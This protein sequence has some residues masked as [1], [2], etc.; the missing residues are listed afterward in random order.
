MDI[1][2]QADKFRDVFQNSLKINS[3]SLS[4]RTLLSERNQKRI[5]YSPYYQRNY[6]WD[7]EKQSFFIESIILGTE[8]PPLILFK[9]G[10]KIEVI[11]G[12]QRFETL[13][14]FMESDLTLS[15]KGLKE[16]RNLGKKN[17]NT[18]SEELKSTFLESNIRVFEF[19]VINHPNL[20]EEIVD[21]VKKEIFRRYNTGITP[22]TRSELDSAKYDTDIFSGHFERVLKEDNDFLKDFNDCFF[23]SDKIYNEAANDGIVS[24]NVDQIR[25]FRILSEFPISTYAGTSNRT[26]II[27]LLYDFSNTNSIDLEKDFEDLKRTIEN[28]LRIY[29]LL[30]PKKLTLNK[31]IFECFIW[32]HSILN[33]E[34]IDFD[35]SIGNYIE[36]I[37][38][39][40]HYFTMDNYHYYRNIIERYKITADFFKKHTNF[41]F[42]IYIR[43]SEFSRKISDLRQTEE[44][45]SK[46]IDELSHLRSHKQNPTSIPVDEIRHDLKTSNYLVRPS[47]QRQE[48]INVRKASSIIESIL[49]GI[50]LPPIFVFK[51]VNGVK[52]VVDGQQRLLSIIGFLGEEFLDEN[53]N[54]VRSKN[55]NFK[56]NGLTILTRLENNKFSDLEESQKDKLLDFVIDLII[57]EEDMNESFDP[58]DLF[59]RLNY[60]PYPIKVNSFEM[61]NSIVDHEVVKQIK[62]VAKSSTSNWFF[63]RETSDNKP[64][65]ML[66]EE[67]VTSLTYIV[68]NVDKENVIGFFPRIDSITCRLKDKKGLSNFLINLNNTA[69]E[70]ELFIKSIHRTRYLIDK[71]GELFQ[72][73]ISK[74]VFNSFLN[75]KGHQ[76]FRRSLQ[77]FYIIWLVISRISD[78]NFEEKK[79]AI[80]EDI[81]SILVMVKNTNNETVDSDYIINFHKRLE[82]ITLS[83]SI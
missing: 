60:K 53:G 39:N 20:G 65:R 46:S 67:L 12:R 83:H 54:R 50:N 52:E 58:V 16:L 8:V 36:F 17:F 56:L 78:N 15:T 55:N 30:K 69:K 61:W 13:K 31:L 26:E 24:K 29:S 25:R 38:K 62:S 6:I 75:V 37:K 76:N 32:A 5:D 9:T 14:K 68:Y 34:N 41:D 40:S 4:V 73:N 42:S 11:D 47:Y 63:L 66:N 64:D 74:D 2:T 77:D 44:S 22:L 43:D 51:K 10:T 80:L 27:D 35:I 7:R 82:A 45:S 79:E 23:P 70:K 59:I 18:L 1:T 48:K 3:R 21:K 33:A 49:L 19:E 81:L 57:I 71:L 72:Q 28:V